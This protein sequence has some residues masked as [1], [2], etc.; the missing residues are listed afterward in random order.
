MLLVVDMRI[1]GTVRERMLVSYHRYRF[2]FMT[3]IIIIMEI[4]IA[5]IHVN[6]LL[7]AEQLKENLF[8]FLIGT[9]TFLFG[10]YRLIFF[11]LCLITS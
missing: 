7:G 1:E 3:I 2:V 9:K 6:M 11:F 8:D 10:M 5:P 4:Y